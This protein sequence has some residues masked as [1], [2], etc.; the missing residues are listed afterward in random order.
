MSIAGKRGVSPFIAQLI[1]KAHRPVSVVDFPVL[2]AMGEP[3]S[4]VAIRGLSQNEEDVAFANAQIYVEQLM[5]SS[6]KPL[7]KPDELEHNARASEILAVACRQVEDQSLPFFAHGVVDTR[8]FGTDVL[9]FMFLAYLDHRQKFYPRLSELD[10]KTFEEW[11][12]K[13]A[14]GVGDDPFFVTSRGMLEDFSRSAVRFL[15]EARETIRTLT[16]SSTS[17]PSEPVS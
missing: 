9:G 15:V 4:R 6:E 17:E 13:I 14:L 7:W 5:R 12:T 2:D 1:A 8:E 10:D 11:V 3:V 16:D